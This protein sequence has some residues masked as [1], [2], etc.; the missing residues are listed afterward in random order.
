MR[1][2]DMKIEWPSPS[3]HITANTVNANRQAKPTA[4][5]IKSSFFQR[6]IFS[7][8]WKLFKFS[9]FCIGCFEV[10]KLTTDAMIRT[11]EKCHSSKQG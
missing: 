5:I 7:P 1:V 2:I 9:A 11:W 10:G 4:S 8:S 3:G 6:S